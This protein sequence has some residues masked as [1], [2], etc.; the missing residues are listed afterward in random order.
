MRVMVVDDS[1]PIRQRV[2]AEFRKAA[3]VSAV[4]EAASGEEALA[5]VD[6]FEPDAVVLDLMLPGMT[7]IEVLEALKAGHPSTKVTVFTNYP[8]SP[9]R[10]RCLELGA[11][12]FFGKCTD[13][14][15]ILASVLGTVPASGDPD[16][17]LAGP[18]NFVEPHADVPGIAPA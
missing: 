11:S 17:R 5:L 4:E 9:L 6:E 2:L 14:A 8:Y 18:V 3:G 10:T 1:T 15:Q 13:I 16:E 7:G 12:H